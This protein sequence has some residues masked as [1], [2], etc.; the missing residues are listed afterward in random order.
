MPLSSQEIHFKINLMSLF[1]IKSV[2]NILKAKTDFFFACFFICKFSA[3]IMLSTISLLIFW[4]SISNITA[5]INADIFSQAEADVRRTMQEI[6]NIQAAAS[7]YLADTG[8]YP[9]FAN[10]CNDAITV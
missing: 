10:N 3:S 8:E 2:L 7:G 1:I 4:F 9:D 6:G 5:D